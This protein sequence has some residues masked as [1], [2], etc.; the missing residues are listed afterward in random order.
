MKHSFATPKTVVRSNHSMPK[1]RMKRSADCIGLTRSYSSDSEN[2]PC[3]VPTLVG[4]NKSCPQSRAPS[5]LNKRNAGIPLALRETTTSELPSLS[6]G[7]PRITQAPP[8]PFKL[9]MRPRMTGPFETGDLYMPSVV[10]DLSPPPI[11]SSENL[12]LPDLF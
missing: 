9:Q 1:L 3:L 2:D 7:L 5:F 6:E 8:K 11:E 12:Y 4:E 10:E